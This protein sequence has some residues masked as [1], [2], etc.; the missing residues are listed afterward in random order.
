[1]PTVLTHHAAHPRRRLI[2]LV[3]R[4]LPSWAWSRRP[5]ESLSRLLGDV[6]RFASRARFASWNGAAPTATGFS[7]GGLAVNV[8][9][10]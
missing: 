2:Y 8:T 3:A 5:A 9:A 6:T 7:R 4:P 10:C 1:M